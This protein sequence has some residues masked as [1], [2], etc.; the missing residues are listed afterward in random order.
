M[1]GTHKL[2]VI[3]CLILCSW[4]GFSLP[5]ADELDQCFRG[6]NFS[7][8]AF[9]L[10]PPLSVGLMDLINATHDDTS[11]TETSFKHCPSP[12]S[13]WKYRQQPVSFGQRSSQTLFLFHFYLLLDGHF[14][15]FYSIG[16]FVP[17]GASCWCWF[18]H[19]FGLRRLWVFHKFH[20]KCSH[21]YCSSC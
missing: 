6:W 7:L 10:P 20:Y 17:E 4:Y 19:A 8:Q 5:S 11:I 21:L 16:I 2:F 1:Q 18:M 14:V 9:S 12:I 13:P 3:Q 15:S